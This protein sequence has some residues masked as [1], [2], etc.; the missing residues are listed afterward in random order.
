MMYIFYYNKDKII[1]VG[2]I[3]PDYYKERVVAPQL[4][5]AKNVWSQRTH[6]GAF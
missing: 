1:V 3:S 2:E 6:W 4:G 5:R